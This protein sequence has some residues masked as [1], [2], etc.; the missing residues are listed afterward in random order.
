MRV[1][2]GVRRVDGDDLVVLLQ[3]GDQVV[4][5]FEQLR[6]QEAAGDIVGVRRDD[7]LEPACGSS[8]RFDRSRSVA[9][10]FPDDVSPGRR[11]PIA[12]ASATPA[13]TA[14]TTITAATTTRRDHDVVGAAGRA[15]TPS[16]S[17]RI[18]AAARAV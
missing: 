5:L 2:V 4:V 3:R 8:A 10:E 15:S 7:R 14:K 17:A 16:R 18:T 12:A 13:P 9:G 6:E 1:R 11:S